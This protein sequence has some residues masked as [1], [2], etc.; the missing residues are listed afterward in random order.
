LRQSGVLG[1]FAFG[2]NV[3]GSTSEL[4]SNIGQGEAPRRAIEEPRPQ[5]LLYPTDGFGDGR[6]GKLQLRRRSGE[7][8]KFRDLGENRQP[9]EVRPFPQGRSFWRFVTLASGFDN[10]KDALPIRAR[11]RVLGAMVK[12]GEAVEYAFGEGGYGYLGP[13]SGEVEVNGLRINARDG[14]AIKDVAVV[15]ITAIVNSEVVMVDAAEQRAKLKTIDDNI[16]SKVIVLYYSSYGHIEAIANAVAEGARQAGAHVDIK[17]VPE[18][19][20]EE[21]ARK[22]HYKF[23]QAAPIA[24]SRT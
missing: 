4:P 22:S 13:A 21:I 1:C 5:A 16:M 14:A 24:K 20:P 7:G 19:V 6:F 11:A 8:A 15:R 3:R 9:F 12:A 17:R 10:D 2:K 18:L 23:D